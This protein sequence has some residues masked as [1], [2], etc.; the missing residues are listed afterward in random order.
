MGLEEHT[1]E[2]VG[3]RCEVCG[4][5]LTARESEVALEA[6]GPAL[7]SVHVAELEPGL[8]EET[9]EEE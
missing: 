1:L 3:D 2:T 8:E 4:A 7:C 6:G 5:A 9:L